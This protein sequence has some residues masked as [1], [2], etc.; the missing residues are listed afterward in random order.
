MV[1]DISWGLKVTSILVSDFRSARVD[2][3]WFI[4][5][6]DKRQQRML[7]WWSVIW[8]QWLCNFRFLTA[9]Y[10]NKQL[11]SEFVFNAL[12]GLFSCQCTQMGQKTLV[13]IRSNIS[14]S[15]HFNTVQKNELKCAHNTMRG[16][17]SLMWNLRSCLPDLHF[18]LSLRSRLTALQLGRRG[19]SSSQECTI[20]EVFWLLWNAKWCMCDSLGQSYFKVTNRTNCCPACWLT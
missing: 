5:K 8:V 20:S 6:V 16:Y 13:R 12:G 15:W 1:N 2:E 14:C 9:W 18:K 3:H 19:E 17:V 4:C 10:E 7:H 11:M